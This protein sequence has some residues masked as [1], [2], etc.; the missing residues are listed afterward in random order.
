MKRA[1]ARAGSAAK[2][3]AKAEA[4]AETAAA[5]AWETHAQQQHTQHNVT[6]KSEL[7]AIE[8]RLGRHV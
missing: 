3:G 5:K 2:V 6:N 8:S 1:A 7:A 4:E